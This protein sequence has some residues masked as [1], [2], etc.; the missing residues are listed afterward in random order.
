MLLIL[1]SFGEYHLNYS[2]LVRDPEL[3]GFTL[4]II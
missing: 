4:P 1:S 3:I 2:G